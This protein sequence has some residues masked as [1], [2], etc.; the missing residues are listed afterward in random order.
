LG[1]YD[2]AWQYYQAGY[3]LKEA[4]NDPEGMAAALIQQ[5]TIARLKQ[6]FPEAEYLYQRSLI[7]YQEINDQGGLARVLNGLGCTAAAQ[8]DY[9]VARQHF[10]QALQI[11]TDIGFVP[12]VLS[13]LTDIGNLLLESGQVELGLELLALAAHHPASEHETKAQAR[14]ILHNR[15]ATVS[16]ALFAGATRRGRDSNLETIVTTVQAELATPFDR[17]EHVGRHRQGSKE[18]PP[19]SRSAVLVEP[20]TSRELE[21][22]QLMAEGRTNQQI[23]AELIISV[24]TAKW[25]TSEIYGKLNVNNRTQAVARARELGLLQ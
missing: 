12:L 24:G 6:S 25:Y 10:Q 15:Q 18:P 13:L 2:R 23:A 4:L 5:G 11:A 1:H 21:V 9:L 7:I 17:E 16:P 8:G 19:L 22:L 3:N 20:L 14:Q